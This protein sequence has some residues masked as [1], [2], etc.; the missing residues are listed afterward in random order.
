VRQ[1][2]TVSLTME[3]SKGTND[4]ILRQVSKYRAD[5]TLAV[6]HALSVL[7]PALVLS[8]LHSSFG[9]SFW[10]FVPLFALV[11][12][13]A[14]IIFHD[15]GHGSYFNNAQM[16]QVAE[17]VFGMF[18]LT[19]STWTFNHALHHRH[20]GNLNAP[21]RWSDTVFLTVAQYKAL[22]GWQRTLY[23]MIRDP[24]VF[25]FLVPFGNFIIRQ[26]IAKSI[27]QIPTVMLMN[28][29]LV[30]SSLLYIKVFGWWSFVG[31]HV[32][33]WLAACFGFMLF[34]LQHSYNPGYVEVQN[35]WDLR[36]SALDGSSVLPIPFWLKFF[37]MG[38]E[39]HSIH[40]FSTKVPGY[41]LKACYDTAPKGIFDAH[42]ISYP[43]MWQ[44]LQ[45]ALY[46]LEKHRYVKFSEVK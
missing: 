33:G 35:A 13:K 45:Y 5:N 27:A 2:F 7:L 8:V 24:V 19:P 20:S 6:F 16:N 26:R 11:I 12:L 4:A 28:V 18:C 17:F 9:L 14:F 40:H 38:I 44:M 15:A 30:V 10:I 31:Y 3:D 41:Q 22:P 1:K 36:K 43:E 37:T 29:A 25:F 42:V 23:R 34:H 46:D 21:F 32:A 39:Y